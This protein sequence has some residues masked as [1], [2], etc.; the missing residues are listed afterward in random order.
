[1]DFGFITFIGLRCKGIIT[2]H[3]T[4]KSLQK[5]FP[6]GKGFDKTPLFVKALK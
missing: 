1:M 4:G 3:E 2:G 5:Y 6:N